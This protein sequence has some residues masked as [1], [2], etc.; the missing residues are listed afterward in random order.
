MSFP[1]YETSIKSNKTHSKSTF[2]NRQAATSHALTDE[3]QR[4]YLAIEAGP[5]FPLL[6]R[7]IATITLSAY[8]I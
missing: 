2:R 7:T 5:L 6:P 8:T 4:F 1:T 3:T